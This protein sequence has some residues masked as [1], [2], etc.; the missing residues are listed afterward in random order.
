MKEKVFSQFKRIFVLQILL[1]L[2][3]LA[4]EYP[5][6]PYNQGKMD[7]QLTGW[8]LNPA[9]IE[10]VSKHTALRRPGSEPGGVGYSAWKEFGP[11]TPSADG[12]GNP[13]WYVAFHEATLK[14]VS[15][16]KTEKGNDVDILLV[17]DSITA[18]WSGMAPYEQYPHPFNNA[19]K[20]AFPTYSAVNIGIGGDKTQGVLWRLDHGGNILGELNPKVVI[21][22]IGHNNMYF[23]PETGTLNAAKGVQWCAK[24]LREKFPKAHVIVVKVLPNGKP[25]ENFYKDAKA[26]NADLDTLNLQSDPLIHVL[27]D[28]WSEMTDAD[29]TVKEG[30]LRDGVHPS[31]AGY[32]IFAAKLKPLVDSLLEKTK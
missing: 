32:A 25:G 23:T 6:A 4:L 21:L 24:N 9:M 11:V 7:P 22:A 29:G 8:P 5:Y 3:G 15:A 31:E 26:I 17:G 10:Y 13:N 30:L 1:T 28:L 14:Q 20:A 27:P 18:Q 16:Y 2:S 19:W 12:D